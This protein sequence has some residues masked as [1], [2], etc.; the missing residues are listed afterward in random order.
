MSCHECGSFNHRVASCP[1]RRN[2]NSSRECFN[3]KQKGHFADKCPNPRYSSNS[4]SNSSHSPECYNCKERGHLAASCPKKIKNSNYENKNRSSKQYEVTVKFTRM[5]GSNSALLSSDCQ[6]ST[7][8]T[9]VIEGLKTAG[10]LTEEDLDDRNVNPHIEIQSDKDFTDWNGKKIA[11]LVCGTNSA[12]LNF[13]GGK[14]CTLCFKKGLFVNEAALKIVYDVLEPYIYSFT[15]IPT[16]ESE[17]KLCIICL[18]D[19]KNCCLLPC[20]HVC[21]C[22]NCA[23]R[24]SVCPNCRANINERKRI[25][26]S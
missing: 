26:L 1:K 17:D 7:A 14:H 19:E 3:C 6:A 2:S 8:K 15:S 4:N 22:M 9:A 13:E 23:S 18:T 5:W 20:G 10:F 21:S 12:I 16:T 11:F 24:V 25:Y